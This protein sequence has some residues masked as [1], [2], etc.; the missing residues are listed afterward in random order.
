MVQS[1][2]QCESEC[3]GA[4]VGSAGQRRLID[5]ARCGFIHVVPLPGFAEIRKLYQESF[6][7]KDIPDYIPK[8]ERER[9]YWFAVYHERLAVAERLLGKRAMRVL[10]IG[11]SIGFFLRVAKDRGWGTQGIEPSRTAAR[12][13]Q[14]SGVETINDVVE[15]VSAAQL[16]RYSL[17]HMSFVLEHVLAPHDLL[18][19]CERLLEQGGVVCIE[20]PNEFSPLQEIVVNRM[21]KQPYWIT[22]GIVPHHLNYFNHSSLR[23]L[24]ERHG[25][26]VVHE[27][28]TFPMEL[29]LLMGEDYVGNDDVG[30]H[31]HSKRVALEMHLL[32]GNSALKTRLYEKF[33]Q[34]GI[35]R[36]VI[37]FATK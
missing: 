15:N 27:T 16:G 11:S 36:E 6:Y 25:F 18:D 12:Y 5:C 24:L 28:A 4:T 3:A 22:D 7:E 20:V 26:K 21:G 37:T 23:G 17:V 33:A 10:D 9:E 14:K 31:A 2:P 19:T 29:F 34:V 30:S 13:A 8:F 1:V 32:K 35:G